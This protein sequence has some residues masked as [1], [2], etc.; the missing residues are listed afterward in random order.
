MQEGVA[1]EAG[2]SR[3]QAKQKTGKGLAR[4]AGVLWISR[5]N[6]IKPPEYTVAVVKDHFPLDVGPKG[7]RMFSPD[8]GP[9]GKK[10][11]VIIW[12]R[13][14]CQGSGVTEPDS[15]QVQGEVIF[16]KFL[17]KSLEAFGLEGFSRFEALRASRKVIAIKPHLRSKMVVG[18]KRR[19][20]MSSSA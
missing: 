5:W 16:S 1:Y 7:K 8:Q 9:I 12:P 15:V 13:Q 10:L 17:R 2:S 6:T 3:R 19:P 4:L 11:Q 20:G 14:Q 18:A